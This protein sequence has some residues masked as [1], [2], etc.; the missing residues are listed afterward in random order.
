MAT[1][2]CQHVLHAGLRGRRRPACVASAA[3]PNEVY[4]KG[5]FRKDTRVP[6]FLAPMEGLADT[7]FRTALATTIGGFDEACTEFIRVPGDLPTGAIASR[8]VPRLILMSGYDAQELSPVPLA[9]QIM[10]SNPPL[11]AE[12]TRC[13][14]LEYRAHRVDL[15]CGAPSTASS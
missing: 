9:V 4:A 2:N 8:Y 13:L 10:G 5:R 12:A 1:T 3:G 15:N 11:L 6:L 7:P 14:A